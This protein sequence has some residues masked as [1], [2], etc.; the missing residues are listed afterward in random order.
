[1]LSML[2]DAASRLS[3]LRWFCG[4]AEDNDIDDAEKR[5]RRRFGHL[6]HEEMGPFLFRVYGVGQPERDA[7]HKGN[8]A[9]GQP[10]QQV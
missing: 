1:M 3:G 7:Q 9:A 4:E 10:G 5:N 6:G 2:C 8:Q